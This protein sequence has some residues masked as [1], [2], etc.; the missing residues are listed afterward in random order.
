MANHE[1]DYWEA[2]F[3]TNEE[4]RER[5]LADPDIRRALNRTSP[6]ERVVSGD[7]LIRL[8]RLAAEKHGLDPLETSRLLEEFWGIRDMEYRRFDG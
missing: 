7:E 3:P 1:L 4:R 5:A 8:E 2:Q 6:T